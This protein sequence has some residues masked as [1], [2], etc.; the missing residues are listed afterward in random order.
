MRAN[1]FAIVFQAFCEYLFSTTCSSADG[2]RGRLREPPISE[3]DYDYLA[4]A[5]PPQ[6]QRVSNAT[7]DQQGA[8]VVLESQAVPAIQQCAGI[9]PSAALEEYELPAMQMPAQH[10]I[11]PATL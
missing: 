9:E 2:D 10:K 11:V 1:N 5:V 6:R 4:R 3:L 7:A 8:A